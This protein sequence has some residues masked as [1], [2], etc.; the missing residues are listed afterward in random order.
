MPPK[1]FWIYPLIFGVIG[2]FLGFLIRYAFTGASFTI[3]FKNILQ[4]HSHVMLLGFLFNALL[5]LIWINF[6]KVMDKISYMLFIALQV[7]IALMTIAFIY[8]GY[9]FFSILFSTL[10]LWISY[11]LLIRLWKRLEGNK[12]IILFVK[13]GIIFH[14]L[15]SLGPYALGILMA[16]DLK[17][18]PWYQQAIFFYLHFQFLGVYF[19]WILALLIKKTKLKINKKQ[20]LIITAGLIFLYTHSLDYSFDH[21]L[22]HFF[23]GLG[24]MLVFAVL[25]RFWSSFLNMDKHIRSIYY[26][27]LVVALINIAGSFPYFADLAVNNRFILIAWLHFLFLGLYIPFIWVFINKKINLGLWLFYIFSVIASEL[28]LVFPEFFSNWFSV[29]INDLLFFAYLG[30]F[31]SL[32]TVHIILLTKS[33]S[34]IVSF[35]Q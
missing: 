5:V 29:S 34:E 4:A 9:A 18:S 3:S 1:K 25:L 21:W 10:H 23:G 22:I 35:Q 31:L 30:V 26:L 14:F 13:I 20:V 15:S 11:V 17:G 16:L 2:A 8:Q 33:K 24:S 27:I 6:T 19:A 12:E 32:T 7:C 28:L